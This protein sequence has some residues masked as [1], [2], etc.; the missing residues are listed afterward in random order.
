MG[1]SLTESEDVSVRSGSPLT[2]RRPTAP[3][4]AGA[5]VG[6]DSPFHRE[7][8]GR[9]PRGRDASFPALSMLLSLSAEIQWQE[10]LSFGLCS[11]EF[12]RI[13]P[14][15]ARYGL[16]PVAARLTTLDQAT[17][18]H[19]G[20]RLLHAT[21]PH[22]Q[23][24][25]QLC[26][27]HAIVADRS[28]PKHASKPQFLSERRFRECATRRRA[29]LT[30]IGT[31]THRHSLGRS[32]TRYAL[33]VLGVS[34]YRVTTSSASME[35]SRRSI[36]A[37]SVQSLGFPQGSQRQSRQRHHERWQGGAMI[38][39]QTRL[40]TRPTGG[41]RCPATLDLPAKEP[42]DGIPVS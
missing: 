31:I 8:A 28:H 42:S 10:R 17:R 5:P 13:P 33:R 35:P 12:L 15:R 39:A 24:V 25:G 32:T 30:E 37:E 20:G 23:H 18:E 36:R 2:G 7:T 11:H 41:S 38:A 29:S 14:C 6:S 26:Q 3:G 21:C 9:D 16:I 27:R 34:P 4:H 40:R 22:S 19:A 1:T